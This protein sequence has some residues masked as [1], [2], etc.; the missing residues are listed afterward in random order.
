MS[1]SNEALLE[2]LRSEVEDNLKNEQF[3]VEEL[4][5]KAGM[6]RSHLHRKLQE[7]TGQS[8]SQFIRKYRLKK[9]IEIPQG[10]EITASEV[11]LPGKVLVVPLI[12]LNH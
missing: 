9:A 8:I 10:E 4:A 2:K 11:R 6:S 12:S 3:G 7:A 1:S 5:D